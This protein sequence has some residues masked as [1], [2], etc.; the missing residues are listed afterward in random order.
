[1]TPAVPAHG[2]GAARRQTLADVNTVTLPVTH[3]DKVA[4]L[5]ALFAREGSPQLGS[6][7]RPGAAVVAAAT[8]TIKVTHAEKV[9]ALRS[10]FAR[11]GSPQIGPHSRE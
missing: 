10:L 11:P 6:R 3:A 2:Q 8:Q 7:K 5:R 1:M 9:G 4:A